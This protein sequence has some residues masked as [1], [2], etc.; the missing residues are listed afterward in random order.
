MFHAAASKTFPFRRGRRIVRIVPLGNNW[1]CNRTSSE[2]KQLHL[3][4]RSLLAVAIELIHIA[5]N[6]SSGDHNYFL[7]SVASMILLATAAAYAGSER[8]RII[9]RTIYLAA[10]CGAI[11]IV[12]F[13]EIA[14]Q[15]QCCGI[16]ISVQQISG[17][18]WAEIERRDSGHRTFMGHNL[19]PGCPFSW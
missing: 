18:E 15:M 17:L 8:M 9:A 2:V 5:R 16:V 13:S 4:P 1:K 12:S 19:G 11:A 6:D 10:T 7:I 3:H 14:F